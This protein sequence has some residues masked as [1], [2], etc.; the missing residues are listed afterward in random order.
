MQGRFGAEPV[1]GDAYLLKLSR[2]IH[3]N[4]VFALGIKIL[5]LE[6]KRRHLRSLPW[7][8]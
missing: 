1:A 7:S 5:A 3:L 8:S 2:Y 6:D 4:P